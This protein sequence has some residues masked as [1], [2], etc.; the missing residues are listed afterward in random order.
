ETKVTLLNAALL[1][2]S[3]FEAFEHD[4]ATRALIARL[5]TEVP[6]FRH[7]QRGAS[8]ETLFDFLTAATPRVPNLR[9]LSPEL[10][11]LAVDAKRYA[12]DTNNLRAAASLTDEEPL[13]ADNLITK[14]AVWEY[15]AENIEDYL[16]LVENDEHTAGSCA[17]SEVLTLVVNEQ[18]ADWSAE[19]M[20]MFLDASAESS[21]LPDITAVEQTA[22]P[23]VV[24]RLSVV[25]NFTNLEAYATEIGVDDALAALFTAD[26]G[27]VDIINVED[28]TEERLKHLIPLVLNAH[29]ALEAR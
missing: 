11:E 25:P 21:A 28:A 22:W 23:T 15:C 14:Q 2:A 9:A 7:P 1:N 29:A 13:N 26:G 3:T 4:E 27:V 20:E 17:S 12:L 16:K 18:H 5:H 8:V 24:D 6:A 10:Q 19:Q